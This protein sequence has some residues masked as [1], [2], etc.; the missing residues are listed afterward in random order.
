MF[1]VIQYA[2]GMVGAMQ[3]ILT[4]IKLKER[5]NET[6]LNPFQFPNSVKTSST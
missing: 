4:I 3:F 5:Y 1:I 2:T 6:E